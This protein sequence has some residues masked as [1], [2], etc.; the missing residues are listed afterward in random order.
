M[1][2][3]ALGEALLFGPGLAPVTRR[4]PNELP[5][6]PAQRHGSRSAGAG[7]SAI[8][9]LIGVV[10]RRSCNSTNGR[11]SRSEDELLEGKKIECSARRPPLPRLRFPSGRAQIPWRLA[12]FLL[13]QGPLVY[14]D[15]HLIEYGPHRARHRI[16]IHAL[17]YPILMVR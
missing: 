14:V 16:Q 8:F 2:V 11:A 7:R 12:Q 4:D 9:C 5:L 13:R 6:T 15:S 10:S 3:W 1:S 17:V